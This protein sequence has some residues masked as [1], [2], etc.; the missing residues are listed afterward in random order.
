MRTRGSG[1]TF[2]VFIPSRLRQCG[3]GSASRYAAAVYLEIREV[4][5]KNNANKCAIQSHIYTYMSIKSV[6]IGEISG[7][8]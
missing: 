7:T 2:A 3:L 4:V 5:F 1:L 8:T 6:I